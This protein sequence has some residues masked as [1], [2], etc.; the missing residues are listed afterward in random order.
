MIDGGCGPVGA[1]HTNGAPQIPRLQ[2]GTG[3]LPLDWINRK[4]PMAPA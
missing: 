1:G 2:A 4:A 3:R